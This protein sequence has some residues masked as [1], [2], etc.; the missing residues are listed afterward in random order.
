M[1]AA[2]RRKR[3]MGNLFRSPA[4][5]LPILVGSGF[6]GFAWLIGAPTGLPGILGMVGI[7]SGLGIAA[8]KLL[9]GR[10]ELVRQ[11]EEDL[12]NES[13]RDHRSY[14][15]R[16]HRRLRSDKDSRTGQY[17]AE[18]RRL[19]DRL[20]E[21]GLM[22]SKTSNLVLPEVRNKAEQIYRS[23]LSCLEQS[24]ELWQAAQEMATD[25]AKEQLLA[26]REKLLEE[27]GESVRH[28]GA[29]VDHLQA[30][31]LRQSDESESLSHMREELEQGLEVARR[32]ERR[33]AEL[34]RQPSDTL[35]E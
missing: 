13:A 14:L 34:T 5:H 6:L 9:F 17:L 27:L 8:A 35:S 21:A 4:V 11:A 31:G 10:D 22:G 7:L 2:S 3:V 18:L 32:V 20:Q 28:L 1:D 23:C 30:A 15:R 26:S 24:L 12:R 19:Y 25:A 33:M 16:L 29:T